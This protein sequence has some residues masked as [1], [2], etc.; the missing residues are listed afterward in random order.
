[1][2]QSLITVSA[3][4]MVQGD[5]ITVTLT[6]IDGVGVPMIVGG[7]TV[8]FS[9]SGGTSIGTLGTTTDSGDGIYQGILT[10]IA[11]GTAS[12]VTV[13][14]DGNNATSIA[15]QSVLVNLTR[16]VKTISLIPATDRA[17]YQQLI[18][19]TPSNFTYANA[20]ADAKDLRFYDSSQVLLTHWVERWDNAGT[21]SIWVKF[22]TAGSSSVN[23]YYG[24]QFLSNIENKTSLFSY[25]TPKTLYAELHNGAGAGGITTNIISYSAGNQIT[26][27][28]SGGASSLTI[29]QYQLVNFPNMIQGTID[30][31]G[32]LA[33][34]ALDV[35]LAYD[36]IAPLAF[37]GTVFG[38][39]DSR[40][41]DRWRIYNP[42]AVTS[43]VT[44]SNYTAGGV[45]LGSTNFNVG[46]GAFN[47]T[48]YDTSPY[49]L[50]ESDQPILVYY[51]SG[52]ST[53]GELLAPPGTEVFGID[54]SGGAIGFTQ[55][56]TTGTIFYSTGITTALAGDKGD[57]YALPSGGLQGNARGLR[58]VT[59][60]PVVATSQADSDGSEAMA[61][62][63]R[64]E[65]DDEYY[66]PGDAQYISVACPYSTFITV[67]N[68]AGTPI[69]SKLCSPSGNFPG[70]AYF[71]TGYLAGNRFQGDNVFFA[72][73]E[74]NNQDETTML[75]PKQGRLV[76]PNPPVPS[77]G[78]EITN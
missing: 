53:D 37:A 17:E 45:F 13:S 66:L 21:S 41:P 63:P 39:P 44:I 42:S 1:M 19:L 2:T 31:M 11:F 12:N 24:N 46:P 16:Y 57:L 23:M 74:Y 64:E 18:Q 10:G 54:S 70:F 59:D 14:I 22:P 52:G 40:G 71:S 38:F 51:N 33:G 55:D 5:S 47:A 3:T 20:E 29:A 27:Q 65:L 75:G 67:Y 77:V 56:G 62:W 61:F 9:Y 36:S 34:R 32:P 73:F 78:P 76:T 48:D 7:S 72:Y 58:I 69:E 50:V 15:S 30:A 43:N 60:K 4:K 25:S 8:V 6:G 49:G 68:T 35:L 26:V 28:E